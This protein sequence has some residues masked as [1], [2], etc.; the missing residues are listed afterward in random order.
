MTFDIHKLLS[1]LPFGTTPLNEQHYIINPL[2]KLNPFTKTKFSD[3]SSYF[4]PKTKLNIRCFDDCYVKSE[5]GYP[6]EI[7]LHPKEFSKPVNKVDEIAHIHDHLYQNA[8]NNNPDKTLQDK[9][10]SDRFMIE[11]LEKINPK[12]FSENVMK[13]VGQMILSSKVKLGLFKEEADEIHKPV[14][15]NY[16]RRIIHKNHLNEIFSADLADM[17]KIP[18]N[19]YHYIFC[20]ID[21]FSKYGYLFPLKN[22]TGKEIITC[23]KEI[24]KERKCLKLWTDHGSEFMNK[25]VQSF[26]KS[27]NVEWYTTE[28]EKKASIAERFIKT[29]KLKIWKNF[30]INDNEKWVEYL[31]E[32]MKNYNNEGHAS[33]KFLTPNEAS[34]KRLEGIIKHIY[35]LKWIKKKEKIKKPRFNIGDRVRIY[36]FRNTFHKSYFANFSKEI[37][38]IKNINK[39]FPITYIL[40]DD[41][42]EEI[43]GCF[44]EQEII[45]TKF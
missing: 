45:P 10:N 27:E 36:A 6:T 7:N 42:N 43:K 26:L 16:P 18:D 25:E 15:I 31:P 5:N 9:H 40:E 14:R 8:E 35:Y 37:F 2:N 44:Y 24:F 12:D 13:K 28:S 23:L 29:I 33:L 11:A 19:G 39:T 20:I 32:I 4:G 3:T 41:K 30:T 22:K 38:I 1:K 17:S 21:N 34:N